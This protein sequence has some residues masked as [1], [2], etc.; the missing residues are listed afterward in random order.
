MKA[1]NKKLNDAEQVTGPWWFLV[2]FLHFSG[3]SQ[4]SVINSMLAYIASYTPKTFFV[5]D[6][7]ISMVTFSSN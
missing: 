3:C 2:S 4:F 1:M 5:L 6:F 7:L